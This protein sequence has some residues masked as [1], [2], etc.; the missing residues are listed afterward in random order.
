MDM[1]KKMKRA[2]LKISLLMG[3]TLS[4][5]LSIAGGITGAMNSPQ[6]FDVRGT[7][8]SFA[9][10]FVISLVIGFLVPMRKITDAAAKKAGS[11]QGTLG[12]R[13]LESVISDL[14]YTPIITVAMVI[15]NW[16]M[17]TMHAPAGQG[18]QLGQMLISSLVTMFSI[19]FVL[20][21]IFMPIYVKLALKSEGLPAPGEGIPPA[22]PG[23]GR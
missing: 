12:R 15:M 8:I 6:G 21:F 22:G 14:I 4:F 2:G 23:A 13:C 1:Q 10:S 11:E 17:A 5:F 18:P 16:K 9:V 19:G 20:I 7:L 3:V